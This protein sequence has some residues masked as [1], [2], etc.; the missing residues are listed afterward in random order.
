[1]KKVKKYIC[2]ECLNYMQSTKIRKSI[3]LKLIKKM[4]YGLRGTTK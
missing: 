1:M 2:T 4:N 3:K